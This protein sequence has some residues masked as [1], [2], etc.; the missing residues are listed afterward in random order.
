MI[1]WFKVTMK[2]PVC[3]G[4]TV[5]VDMDK[6]KYYTRYPLY[7][8]VRDYRVM[9]FS[10]GLDWVL[11]ERIWEEFSPIPDDMMMDEGL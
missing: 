11:Q 10:K 7:P 5:S 8:D 2:N 3:A 9:A 1:R 4:N 6:V